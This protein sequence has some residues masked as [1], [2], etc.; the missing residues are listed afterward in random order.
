MAGLIIIGI[1]NIIVY[2]FGENLKKRD[3]DNTTFEV[4][5]NDMLLY[6][7]IGLIIIGMVFLLVESGVLPS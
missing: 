1:F 5:S 6:S 2:I 4:M 3:P 7:G